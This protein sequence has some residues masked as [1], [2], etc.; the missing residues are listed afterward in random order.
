MS[1]F[2]SGESVKPVAKYVPDVLD[3]EDLVRIVQDGDAS[4]PAA[5]SVDGVPRGRGD[6]D[7]ISLQERL[8][9]EDV[10]RIVLN[11]DDG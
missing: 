10:K 5:S 1:P 6:S 7:S 9:I 3:D 8:A 11:E 4:W 2:L